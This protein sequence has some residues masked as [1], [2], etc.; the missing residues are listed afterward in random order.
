MATCLIAG[1]GYVGGALAAQLAREGH[2]VIAIRRNLA[3]L[4]ATVRGLA[5]DLT[6]PYTLPADL[7]PIDTVVLA[8]GA[9]GRTPEA[10]TAAYV[11]APRLL[12]AALDA[13]G[14]RP[15]RCVYTSSTGVF[16]QRGG[17]VVDETSPA[18]PTGFS[19]QALLAGEAVLAAS[20]QPWTVL[21]LAGIY[22]P[23]RASLIGDVRTGTARY[24]PT[25][26]HWSSL[27]HRD[28]A[29][30][31]IA[32]LLL[33]L[34]DPEPLYLGV[35]TEPV[36]RETIIR[37]LCGRLGTDPDT[38]ADPELPALTRGDKRCSCNRLLGA[39]MVFRY[40]SFREGYGALLA[41]QAG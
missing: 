32:L 23:G 17:A 33:E 18:V 14:H 5:I 9:G 27:I 31:A 12:V 4:P 34:R 21:R 15:H 29:V 35:D 28:D 40:P 10:Y 1:A 37:W 24:N 25:R 22:G 8:L 16:H 26:P 39:G 7:P 19:G 3:A 20:G 2:E 11:E 13:A 6:R 41:A 38:L 30:N 36:P